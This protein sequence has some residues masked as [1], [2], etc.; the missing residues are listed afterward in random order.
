MEHFTGRNLLLLNMYVTVAGSLFAIKSRSYTQ[1]DYAI[2]RVEYQLLYNSKRTLYRSTDIEINFLP[3]TL[4]A[5]F[6]FSQGIFLKL[7]QSSYSQP[8]NPT[9]Y[10]SLKVNLLFY[11]SFALCM[12]SYKHNVL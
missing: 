11:K 5:V 4:V 7:Q 3:N 9:L 10:S 6:N 1:K 12:L 8:Y 2:G